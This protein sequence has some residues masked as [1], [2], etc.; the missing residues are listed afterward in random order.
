MLISDKNSEHY[1]KIT[2]EKWKAVAN[3]ITLEQAIY[4]E[5]MVLEYVNN[6][7]SMKEVLEDINKYLEINN[8]IKIKK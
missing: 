7:K 2:H 1:K 3:E 5:D 4:C 8:L 6:Q